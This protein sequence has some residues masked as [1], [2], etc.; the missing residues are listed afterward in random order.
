[1]SSY[2]A[3]ILAAGQASRYRSA[4]GREPTKLV[5]LYAGEPLVR[6][7][8]R[9][10]LASAAQPVVLVTGHARGEVED[11]VEGLSV[12]TVH[13]PEYPAGLST[14]L[15]AGL[16]ALPTTCAGAVIL[17]GDM[18]GVDHETIDRLIDR[19]AHSPCA[20]AGVLVHNG[21]RGNPVLLCRSIFDCVHALTG[22][23]GARSLLSDPTLHIEELDAETSVIL[24][25]VD[26]PD[27]LRRV[28]RTS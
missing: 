23:R 4:G 11:A 21:Q 9:A 2:A 24:L 14:S 16:A 25:D 27:D 6:H 1:M 3:V 5:A 26:E 8:A 28:S 22:D 20:D 10:A 17:L 13:N 15:K 7:V 19:M 18:P 12:H